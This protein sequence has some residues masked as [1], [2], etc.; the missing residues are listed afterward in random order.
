MCRR[1]GAGRP[2]HSVVTVVAIFE[3]ESGASQCASAPPLA[4]PA[5]APRFAA[6]SFSS[7]AARV[8]GAKFREPPVTRLE[9]DYSDYITGQNGALA[10]TTAPPAAN[11][12]PAPPEGAPGPDRRYYRLV[13]ERSNLGGQCAESFRS[14]T[15]PEGW[16]R[17]H[18]PLPA[19]ALA[20]V[21]RPVVQGDVV[22]CALSRLSRRMEDSEVPTGAASHRRARSDLC[23]SVTC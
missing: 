9:G 3:G 7:N 16:R 10:L 8:N 6:S 21:V 13:E 5:P 1:G 19:S 4:G 2:L 17:Q 15:H 18:L 20:A 11:T 14:D 23:R 22:G 12:A